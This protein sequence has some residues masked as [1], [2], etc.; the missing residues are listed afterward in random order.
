MLFS[1]IGKRF[2]SEIG[3]KVLSGNRHLDFHV[4][5][6]KI[7]AAEGMQQATSLL[8]GDLKVLCEEDEAMIRKSMVMG[9][10]AKTSMV[11]IPDVK[12]M[13]WHHMREDFICEKLFGKAAKVRGAMAGEP[14]KRVWIIWTRKYDAHPDDAEAGNV[15]YVLRLVIEGAVTGSEREKV[16]ENLKAVIGSAQKEAEEWKLSVVRFWDPNPLVRE[17]VKEMGLDVVEK[18]REDDA[19]ASLRLNEGVGEEEI[20]WLANERYA[21][22]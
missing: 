8:D 4:M 13:E 12:H 19:I 9:D 22:L 15:L 20:E 7:P 11:I 2:Y 3:W 5:S 1:D 17:L 14:G 10:G 6:G 18:E 16:K 21:W